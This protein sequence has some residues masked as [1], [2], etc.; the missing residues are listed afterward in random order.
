[1]NGSALA[2]GLLCA[3]FGLALSFAASRRALAAGGVGL[4]AAAGIAAALPLGPAAG[5]PA[6]LGCWIGVIAAAASVHL[7]RGLGARSALALGLNSGLWAGLVVAA[8]GRPVEL[9][10]AL[11][12]ALACFPGAWLAARGWGVAVKVAASWLAAAAVLNLGLS[13]IPT[14]GYEPDHMG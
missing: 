7:R 9:L 2:P 12:W 14:L 4:V 8:A 1:M 5:G 13:M 3:A 6:L 11:P 10:F